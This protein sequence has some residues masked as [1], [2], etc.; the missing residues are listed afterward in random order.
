MVFSCDI[1]LFFEVLL[2][3]FYWVF[4]LGLINYGG[5]GNKVFGFFFFY[6]NYNGCDDIVFWFNDVFNFD[7]IYFLVEYFNYFLVLFFND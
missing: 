3:I 6:W 2:Y 5:V 4:I 1:E 7:R